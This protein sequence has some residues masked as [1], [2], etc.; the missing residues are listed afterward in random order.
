MESQL[1]VEPIQVRREKLCLI[2]WERCKRAYQQRWNN[3]KTAAERL[4]TQKCPIAIYEELQRKYDIEPNEA[5]PFIRHR[6]FF[7]Q[8]PNANMKLV[9]HNKTCLLYTSRCV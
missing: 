2:S 6:E 4:K 8:L 1:Q 5:A 7:S 3:Y 9:D